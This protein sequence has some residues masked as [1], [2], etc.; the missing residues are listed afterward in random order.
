MLQ[1]TLVARFRDQ[2]SQSQYEE[3]LEQVFQRE[4]APWE[5]VQTL[6]NGRLE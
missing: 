4:L 1:E 3:V 6:L 5:A 2:V